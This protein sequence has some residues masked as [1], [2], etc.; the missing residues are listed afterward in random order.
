M[1]VTAL[2]G[3]TA[4]GVGGYHTCAIVA[5]G[6]VKCWGNNSFGELGD[7]TSVS[8]STSPVAVIGL[9]G[10]LA[11]AAGQQHTCALLPSGAVDCWGI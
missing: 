11:I 7:G 4:L 9:T 3:A 6:A 10:V 8:R 2:T 5:G 1:D